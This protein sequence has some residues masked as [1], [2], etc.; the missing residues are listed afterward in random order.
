MFKEVLGTCDALENMNSNGDF[1][2]KALRG[3]LFVRLVGK[4]G[5]LQGMVMPMRVKA[6]ILIGMFA[7]MFSLNRRLA[8]VALLAPW[9]WPCQAP[10]FADGLEV[11]GDIPFA[12]TESYF[13]IGLMF[14]HTPTSVIV[15]NQRRGKRNVLKHK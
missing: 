8:L 2:N 1:Q 9:S 12:G 6:L 15:D 10:H 5:L 13:L 7:L 14:R 3:D 4:A 11:S